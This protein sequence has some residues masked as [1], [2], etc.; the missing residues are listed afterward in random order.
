MKLA[1]LRHRQ[2][3]LYRDLAAL[4]LLCASTNIANW[5]SSV[6]A[7]SAEN[8]CIAEQSKRQKMSAV[9]PEIEY[10]A[11]EDKWIFLVFIRMLF[12]PASIDACTGRALSQKLTLRCSF[13]CAMEFLVAR[14]R[15]TVRSVAQPQPPD[16]Y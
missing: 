5:V 10:S 2:L 4:D 7:Y 13:K 16:I 8:L 11:H 9:W 1:H 15:M 6:C 14:P 3:Q 12:I